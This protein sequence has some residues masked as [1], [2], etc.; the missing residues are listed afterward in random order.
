MVV[1]SVAYRILL[2]IILSFALIHSTFLF[3]HAGIEEKYDDPVS[4][5]TYA[6]YAFSNSDY[7]KSLSAF[8]DI[9][10]VFPASYLTKYAT[11][12]QVFLQY[13][14]SQHEKVGGTAD[15]FTQL[16]PNDE[17]VPYVQYM[18]ALSYYKKIRIPTKD[19]TMI[20]DAQKEMS[21]VAQM[22]EGT[23][24]AELAKKKILYI[25]NLIMMSEIKIGE[26][27]QEKGYYFAAIRR[28]S[29]I[30]N[31]EY[32]QLT[33]IAIARLI[34]CYEALGITEQSEKYKAMLTAKFPKFP[35][36]VVIEGL[37]SEGDFTSH[38][39][40]DDWKHWRENVSIFK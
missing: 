5:Y 6:M 13:I 21:Y 19:M 23:K 38:T 27:Y 7:S 18:K 17:L 24:Y 39:I 34:E 15:A 40:R 37:D 2:T 36:E 9:E 29:P 26:E 35:N 1:Y 30:L 25:N 12:M 31:E 32:H 14:L 4:A 33:P 10:R 16:Y 3:V 22:Y 8:E 20:F 11:V 28:Y